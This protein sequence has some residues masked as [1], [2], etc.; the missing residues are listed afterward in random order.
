MTSAVSEVPAVDGRRARRERGRTA[1]VD[2]MFELLQEG[3]LPPAVEAIAERAGVSVSSVFRYF[4][5]LDDLQQRT[6]ERYFERFA[7]LFT[8]PATGKG[9]LDERIKRLVDARLDLYDAIGPIALMARARAVESPRLARTLEQT[10]TIQARLVRDHFAT[11]LAALT[12]ARADDLVVLIDSM[13]SFEAWDLLRTA[14]G[15]TRPQIRRAWVLG[16]KALCA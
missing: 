16:L 6:I 5:N 4:E 10:R 2:A 3:Q 8:I 11:E 9:T 1:V 14:H 15:R 12:P 7:S 13:S